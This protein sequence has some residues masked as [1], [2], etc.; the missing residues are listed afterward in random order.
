MKAT[1]RASA[2]LFVLGLGPGA[3]GLLTPE[4]TAALEEASVIVGYTGYVRLVPQHF[5]QGKRVLSTG[6]TGELA[7]AAEAVD[8]ALGGAATA[9]VCSGD[10]GVYALAGLVLE[11]LE[12]R[13][14]P[15]S[16][17]PLHIVPGVP[18]VCAA[19]AL[20]GAPL[21]HDFAC[22]SL[23]D[24]LTPW[25]LI[26]KRLDH[27]FA[28]DFVVA[29]Y[30]PRSKRRVSQ[31]GEAVTIALAHKAGDTPVGI[32]K[33]AFRPGQEVHIAP[34]REL[35]FDL[36]DMFTL[37]IIGNSESRVVPGTGNSPLSWESGA[38]MLTPRGYQSKYDM[39]R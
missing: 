4:A 8:A 14:L 29:L 32:V 16:E 24:L 25:P 10:P 9:L 27:A 2:P 34:L 11:Q 23:S 35:P 31:L 39:G 33:N 18:A 37:L 22:I 1:R 17:L 6:M 12:A 28:A 26:R 13:G 15:P 30:N 36:V 7:R 21:M 3:P 20:L 38:R 5:L 19:A